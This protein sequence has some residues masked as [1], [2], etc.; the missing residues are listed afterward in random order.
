[1]IRTAINRLY[2]SIHEN[3]GVFFA[4]VL[5][6]LA[7]IYTIYFT[8][9]HITI[10]MLFFSI[11]ILFIF[12]LRFSE[13]KYLLIF[14]LFV[15]LHYG[16]SAAGWFSLLFIASYLITHYSTPYSN[17]KHSL[18]FPILVFLIAVVPSMVNIAQWFPSVVLIY[19]LIAFFLIIAILG[20]TISSVKEIRKTLSFFL[21]LVVAASIEALFETLITGK[22]SFG[23]AGIMFTDYS[24]IGVVVSFVFLALSKG[25]KRVV[26]FFIFSICTLGNIATQ[27]R[28]SM[29]VIIICLIIIGIYLTLKASHFNLSRSK[30]VLIGGVGFAIMILLFSAIKQNNPDIVKPTAEISKDKNQFFNEAGYP[31]G[32]IGSRLLIWHTAIQAF[33]AH[34]LIG[35]GIYSFPYSSQYY[36]TIPKV[37]FD[38]YVKGRTPHV[39]YLALLVETGVLG[40]LGFLFFLISSLRYSFHNLQHLK[41]KEEKMLGLALISTLIYISIS[42]FVTD[43]WLLGHGIINFAIIIG[44]LV[45]LG[46]QA[47][48]VA[49]TRLIGSMR[50]W[51]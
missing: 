36:R 39:G 6:S 21:A 37:L 25:L 9:P 19:N 29:I 46:H 34:P 41:D 43:A 16:F 47:D 1:M 12:I 10:V 20:T 24:G 17:L 33:E 4:S 13:M 3:A 22:R 45:A 11:P 5:M 51:R 28:N 38:L 30:F 14:M 50:T 23:I 35:I 42:M 18:T 49:R 8:A 15:D 26:Y 32:S 2:S 44:L 7:A 31:T 27:T 40:L 48:N